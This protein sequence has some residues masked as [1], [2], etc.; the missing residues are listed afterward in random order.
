MLKLY[1]G[2]NF[3][4]LSD[5]LL[6][7]LE[8]FDERNPLSPELF[9][10]QNYGMARR[11]S[12]YMAEKEGI[13]ANLQFKFP[14]EIF[15]Q[16]V[17]AMD[18]S[19]PQTL[20]SERGPMTWALMN[21]LQSDSNSSL[22]QLH[23][24]IRDDDPVKQD[25]RR[26]Q[27]AKRIADVFDQYLTYRPDMLLNWQ[28][29]RRKQLQ[30]LSKM[31]YWQATLWKKLTA[32]WNRHATDEWNHRALL[33]QQLI[34]AI[35]NETLNKNK[36][37][38]HISVFGVSSMPPVYI[39]MLVKLSRIINV[40]F[41]TTA[42]ETA[43]RQL[44]AESLGK[45][46]NE[47]RMLLDAYIKEDKQVIAE[48]ISLG[49]P[50]KPAAHTL[51]QIFKSDLLEADQPSTSTAVDNSIQVHSCHSRRREV[52]VLYD[53]LLA[54]MDD[55]ETLNPF[56]ILVMAPDIESYIPDVNA[57]FGAAEP[58]RLSIPYYFSE[59]SAQLNVVKEAFIKLLALAE[60]RFNITD[61]I[62]VLSFKP[63]FL[64]FKLTEQD[65]PILEQWIAD[66]NIHWGIDSSHKRALGVPANDRFTWQ[67]G[68]NRMLLG[69][70]MN[71]RED[72]LYNDIFPFSEIEQSE[73]AA[74]AGRFAKFMHSLF[75]LH[76]K[77][78]KPRS[79]NEW[80]DV[81]SAFL[82]SFLYDDEPY[83][84]DIRRIRKLIFSLKEQAALS[85]FNG[86][87][88]YGV[89]HS[90]LSEKL[91]QSGA[92]GGRSGMGVTFSSM[93]PM[94]G[95]PSRIICLLGMNDDAFPASHTP[96]TFDL[97]QKNPK[98]GDR[99]HSRDDRQIFLET[100]LAADERLYF[101]YIGKSDRQ[102][103]DFPP[104]VVLRECMDYI[105]E[106]YSIKEEDLVT[107]HRLQAFS[108]AYFTPESHPKL[109]SYSQKNEAIGRQLLQRNS[110]Q[111]VF[112]KG[113]LPEPESSYKQLT[114]NE[115][116]S[117]YQHPA[118]YLLQKR[119]GIYLREENILD[120]DRESFKIGGLQ[121]YHL[122]QELL[123]RHLENKQTASYKKAAAGAGILPDGWPGEYGFKQKD[124]EVKQ[125]S[126]RLQEILRHEKMEPIEVDLTIEGFK[127]TGRLDGLYE[128][129]QALFRFGKKRPK[130][131]IEWWIRHLVFQLVK[132]DEHFGISRLYTT[133]DKQPLAIHQ[134]SAIANS[135]PL[136]IDLLRMY[137]R[138]LRE[139]IVFF[140]D[141]SFAFA[142]DVIE[143][144][145]DEE[146]ALKK[147]SYKWKN[148]H[149]SY[150]L[151]GDDPYNTCLLNNINPLNNSKTEE[152]FKQHSINFWTPF[153][154]RYSQKKG[155]G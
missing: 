94:R 52:E 96:M 141:T 84:H 142:Q 101:S 83:R 21:I 120:E 35:E 4:T 57:I 89:I 123:N 100:L 71:P 43:H 64:K 104:S 116:I 122:G 133:D 78:K 62:D 55:D 1:S 76:E 92:G 146:S 138:G 86:M 149:V 60:S 3:Y 124:N 27:L 56:D 144:S 95:I 17:R 9:V 139:N 107:E 98:P 93:I 90:W 117:F 59:R 151:E 68:L 135:V 77:A 119:F 147:A 63:V 143:N 72:E 2:H 66:N 115:L 75:D 54:M 154:K 102:D 24:Y 26:W 148:R 30:D 82:S 85:A 37:P 114:L 46:G 39:K 50:G 109:F 28:S 70:A 131:L 6:D 103:T 61:I 11:L 106:R 44:L 91:E 74:L 67:S 10:V 97:I 136:I 34:T 48:H 111:F 118:K 29:I 132:P 137:G 130:E 47:F 7:H 150:D 23:D 41:F 42:G 53:H 20:P 31:E 51:L 40:S 8:A 155:A 87:V 126:S 58:D 152:V 105:L 12:L 110:D 121:E 36:L 19:I 79:L 33:Q 45:A 5:A 15:W 125:F 140:P 32:Y 145:K 153:F 81:F 49:G 128:N 113:E 108:P 38:K 127:I 22:Q 99:V 80:S 73:D 112:L 129:E 18:P 65:L 134:L 88:P 16:I 14:A 13:A 69:Y 25:T